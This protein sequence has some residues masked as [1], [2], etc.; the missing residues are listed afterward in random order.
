MKKDKLIARKVHY[1][2]DLKNVI[3]D[4]HGCESEYAGAE[5]VTEY[6]EGEIFWSGNVEI[7]N[8]RG[9][10]TAKRCYAWSHAVGRGGR[11]KRFLAVL[12]LPPVDSPQTA[13]KAVCLRLRMRKESLRKHECEQKCI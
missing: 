7:F 5:S 1:I 9:H 4:L 11:G 2:Q 6:Y 10:P 12:E 13:V 8:I 3:Y